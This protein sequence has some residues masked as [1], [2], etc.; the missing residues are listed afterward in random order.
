MKVFF[1]IIS[2]NQNQCGNSAVELQTGLLHLVPKFYILILTLFPLGTN[3]SYS[4][5]EEE[6]HGEP[7]GHGTEINS[8]TQYSHILEKYVL[9]IYFP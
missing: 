2:V 1:L 6:E 7:N 8:S 4:H 5:M 3:G 9:F